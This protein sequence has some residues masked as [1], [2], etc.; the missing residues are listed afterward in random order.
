MP[1]IQAER[2][3]LRYR[4]KRNP[5]TPALELLPGSSIQ[6]LPSDLPFRLQPLRPFSVTVNIH[7]MLPEIMLSSTDFGAIFI[8][9]GKR[10]VLVHLA[11]V[12]TEVGCGVGTFV[13][14]TALIADTVDHV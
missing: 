9:T 12:A 13:S 2:R 14:L 8:G 3:E 4:V 7:P 5:N 6:C 1:P 11:P 10:L